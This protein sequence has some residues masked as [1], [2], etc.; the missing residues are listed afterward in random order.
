MSGRKFCPLAELTL[1]LKCEGMR[2]KA[3][4][5]R[6]DRRNFLQLSVPK[7]NLYLQPNKNNKKNDNNYET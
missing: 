2:N 4:K 6:G 7:Q 3:E 1:Q 5:V